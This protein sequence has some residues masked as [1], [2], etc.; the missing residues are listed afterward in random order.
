MRLNEHSNRGHQI[1]YKQFECEGH[2]NATPKFGC[3]V[4][5]NGELRGSS[6]D[7]PSKDA[8]KEAAAKQAADALFLP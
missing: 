1:L 4:Y 5:V 7:C 2:T 8:A 6:K 3:Y